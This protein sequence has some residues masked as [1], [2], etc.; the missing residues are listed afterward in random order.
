[1]PR[2][3]T[4]LTALVALLVAFAVPASAATRATAVTAALAATSGSFGATAA[5]VGT[6]PVAGAT[7]TVSWT[8]LD[9]SPKFGQ[10]VNTG[11]LPLS[12]S[13]YTVTKS[14]LAILSTVRVDACVGATWNTTANTCAGTVTVL[15]DST[16]SA[17]RAVAPG[18]TGASLSIRFTLTGL[19]ALSATLSVSTARADARAATTTSS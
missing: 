19:A 8:L 16:T 7:L 6:T 12:F 2:A 4:A 9:G 18:A 15:T 17:T 13:R 5:A 3:V 10:V 11:T 1:M 14:V